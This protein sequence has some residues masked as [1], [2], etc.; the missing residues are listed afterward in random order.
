MVSPK[1]YL[2]LFV[3]P[4][5]LPP[6]T[7]FQLLNN[8]CIIEYSCMSQYCLMPKLACCPW[9]VTIKI[10][11]SIG[12]CLSRDQ[13]MTSWA[14]TCM[15][16]G[17]KSWF[18]RGPWSSHRPPVGQYRTPGVRLYLPPRQAARDSGKILSACGSTLANY[19]YDVR[20]QCLWVL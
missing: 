11:L 1:C 18:S 14:G 6:A 2:P 3:T 17:D 15:R 9:G 19:N 7:S 5:R 13:I 4:C 20:V 8:P 10:Y 12:Y 16:D